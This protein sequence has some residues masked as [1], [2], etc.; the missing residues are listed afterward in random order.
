MLPTDNEYG[1]WAASG[2]IDIM[3]IKNLK[4]DLIKKQ[5]YRG[6]ETGI[7]ASTLHYGAQWPNN[8]YYSSGKVTFPTDF[9]AGFHVFALEWEENQMR[10]YVD[11]TVLFTINTNT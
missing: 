4:L 8:V 3:V 10:Y 9:S 1:T 5:E 7:I 11:D 6:Q 2:E